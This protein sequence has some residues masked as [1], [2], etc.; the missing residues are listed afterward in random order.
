MFFGWPEC[1]LNKPILTKNKPVLWNDVLEIPATS[2]RGVTLGLFKPYRYLST[3]G[4]SAKEIISIIRKFNRSGVKIIVLTFHSFSFLGWNF[5]RSN[6]WVDTKKIAR[7]DNL[8][9]EIAK[10]DRKNVKSFRELYE[11][12]KKN[13]GSILDSPEAVPKSSLFFALSRLIGRFLQIF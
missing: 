3:C 11:I 10:N 8:L 13:P 2:F 1:G 9:R 6:Y 12:F 5:N 4:N 7:F